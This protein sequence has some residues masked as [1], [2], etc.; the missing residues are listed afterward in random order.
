[1][2]TTA[3]KFDLNSC[4]LGFNFR[5]SRSVVL[6]MVAGSS[7]QVGFTNDINNYA[8]C[9]SYISQLV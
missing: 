4:Q 3:I 7:S 8:S 5:I 1:M 2:E 9:S 6:L